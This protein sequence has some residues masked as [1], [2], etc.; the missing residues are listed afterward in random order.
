MAHHSHVYNA[1]KQGALVFPF[2]LARGQQ[3]RPF[4][5]WCD[6][7]CDT[8]FGLEMAHPSPKKTIFF[9]EGQPRFGVISCIK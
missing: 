3:A 5:Y 6:G 7:P 1:D 4:H 2:S 8:P 9:D